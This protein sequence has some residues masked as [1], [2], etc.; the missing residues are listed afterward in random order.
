MTDV[1]LKTQTWIKTDEGLRLEGYVDTTGNYSIGWGRN[2]H[3]GISLDE[4]ELMFQNDLNRTVKELEQYS[5]YIIQP[6]GVKDALINMNF[7][8][9]IHKLIEFT[10]MIHALIAKDYNKAAEE[11]LNSLWAKQLPN[12]SKEITDVIRR[13]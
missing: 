7:N 6:Q 2:L 1:D 13:G 9:G 3:N 12:R 8:L 11:A 5:W 10:G 4:A